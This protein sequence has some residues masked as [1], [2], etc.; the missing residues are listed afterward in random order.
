MNVKQA[1]WRSSAA[2]AI[3]I[4]AGGCGGGDRPAGVASDGDFGDPESGG[5]VVVVQGSDM[6]IPLAM[7]AQS[8]FDGNL[9]GD[10]MYMSL[11]SSAWQ[12]GRLVFLDASQ[13][14]M[15]LAHGYEHAGADSA[16]LRFHMRSDV[17]WSDGQPVTARDIEFTYRILDD[18]GLASPLQHYKE[19]LD[20]VE[21]E[22][23][24]TVVF[25]YSGRHP[26]MVLHATVQPIPEHLFGRTAPG[27][28]RNHPAIRSP[29]NGALV[30]NGPYMIGAWQ[31]GQSVVLVRNPHFEPRAHLDQVVFRIIPDPTTR[32][33]ELQTGAVDM[34]T[35]ITMDQVPRIR[36]Q[37][38]HVRLER[39]EKRFYDYIAYNGESF[40]P[41]ADPDVRRALGLAID[42]EGI[43]A[44]LQM[45]EFAVPAGG[46]YPPIFSDLYDPQGQAPVPYDPDEARRILESKGWRDSDNDGI[47]DRD[48][49]PFRF[50]FVTNTGNQRRADITQIVQQQWRRIGVDARIQIVEF[51]TMTQNLTTGNFEAVLSGWSVALTPDLTPIW[52]PE[53]PFNYT[54]YRN[55]ETVRLIAEARA[56]PSYERAAPIWRQAASRIAQDQPYTWLFF[57]DM[58]DGV[59]NRVRD[60]K[61]DTYGPYQNLW[62]W[63]IPAELRRPGEG[64]GAASGS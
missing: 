36:A 15:A 35:G 6:T 42:T 8:T 3:L 39:E 17:R 41:F 25:H 44:A 29:E 12:D 54:R 13:S 30:T 47:L 43:I 1:P 21:V 57:M 31:R 24:S 64:G 14:P 40:A 34:V 11:L 16:S 4:L 18:P 58:V 2:L 37:A 48:G 9:G 10:V 46:P 53:S 28:L 5:S 38:P 56:Q 32:L 27:D 20:R 62:E 49:Q 60:T 61:I 50:N 26:D 22:D 51:N 23:D 33:V 63:W 52:A 55:P 45:E 59:N 7:L 19:F